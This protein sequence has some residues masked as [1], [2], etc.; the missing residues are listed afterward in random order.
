[1]YHINFKQKENYV[2]LLLEFVLQAQLNHWGTR[3]QQSDNFH[4]SFCSIFSCYQTRK[5]IKTKLKVQISAIQASDTKNRK[6][7]CREFL[8]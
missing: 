7:P 4:Y 3:Y 5:K 2:A 6:M 8:H 1:M